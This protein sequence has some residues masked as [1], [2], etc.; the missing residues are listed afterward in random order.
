MTNTSEYAGAGTSK[1][2][3]PQQ[4]DTARTFE[5][6]LAC[7]AVFFVPMNFL[8][9][10]G[11]YFTLSD[12]FTIGCLLIMLLNGTIPLR[13]LGAGTA[14]WM[15]GLAMLTGG[16]FVSSLVTAGDTQRALILCG[17]YFF[18]YLILPFI[19]LGRP[20]RETRILMLVFIAA[21]T[22]AVL[23]GIYAVE[24]LEER[25]TT[26]VSGSGRLQGF[27]ERENEFGS[28]IALTVPLILTLG[29]TRTM[30]PL[31]ALVLVPLFAYGIMLTGSNTALWSL[32]LALAAFIVFKPTLVRVVLIV[33]AVQA[34]WFM[35]QIEAVRNHL[36]EVF[37]KRVLPGLESGTMATMGTFTDRMELIHE[38]LKI[39]DGTSLIGLG[40]DR[41]RE[42]SEWGAP[43]HNLYL[44]LW[45][46]GGLPSLI[47]FIIMLIGALIT[48]FS[49]IDTRDSK[50]FAVCGLMTIT[51]FAAIVNAVPH[52]YGRF[53]VVPLLL[54]IA[55]SVYYGQARK[56][57]G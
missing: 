14:F 27:V 13:P 2:L 9:L 29:G 20:W 34:F 48:C 42:A 46:E 40:A 3:P 8:R 5:L 47:G 56:T 4:R 28:L 16:M 7:A 19:L 50:F 45:A 52:V 49:S 18:A 1:V 31:L 30:P 43:V 44:L 37:Q 57:T 33:V 11:Y 25:S 39:V 41:Y 23:H 26:W 32:V 55:A 38:A 22:I 54:S 21:V 36:P 51:L 53:W 10:S 15:V 6:V 17:Q 35:T 24:Y 12:A